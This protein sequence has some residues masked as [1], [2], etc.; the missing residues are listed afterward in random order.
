MKLNPD[1]MFFQGDLALLGLTEHADVIGKELP[2]ADHVLATG[3]SN[4]HSHRLATG[5]GAK[6]Y[7]VT[8]DEKRRLGVAILVLETPNQMIAE[9]HDP[10]DMPPGTYLIRRQREAH[11]DLSESMVLD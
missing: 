11:A 8:D 1:L 10:I 6:A 5:A 3:S 7:D 4:S 2:T 9:T